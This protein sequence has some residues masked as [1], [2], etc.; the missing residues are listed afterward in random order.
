[1]MKRRVTIKGN[2]EGQ[3]VLCTLDRTYALKH[4]ETSNTVLLVE[5]RLNVLPVNYAVG[6]VL[7]SC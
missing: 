6:Q 5:V 4:V 2:Q 3:A 1:M 7:T